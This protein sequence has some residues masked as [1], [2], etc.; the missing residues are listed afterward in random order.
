MTAAKYKQVFSDVMIRAQQTFRGSRPN[1]RTAIRAYARARA[2]IRL[3]KKSEEILMTTAEV[4][5]EIAK[6][7]R[8]VSSYFALIFFGGAIGRVLGSFLFEVAGSGVNKLLFLVTTT[9]VAA[10]IY[11]AG[12]GL[13]WVIDG[14][15]VCK[16]R[17][18]CTR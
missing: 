6:L 16:E 1:R 5:K 7:V 15:A 14:F 13:G 2:A 10:I 11:Y 12:E 9:I 18:C 4:T 17:N 3:E 8:R